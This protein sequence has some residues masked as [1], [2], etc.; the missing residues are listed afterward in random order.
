MVGWLWRAIRLDEA[1]LYCKQTRRRQRSAQTMDRSKLQDETH[2]SD[3][4]PGHPHQKL[5]DTVSKML[6]KCDVHRQR[7]RIPSSA[8]V[9]RYF[10]FISGRSELLPRILCG[11][12]D[13]AF[14]RRSLTGG[15]L[16]R[17][18]ERLRF[19]DRDRDRERERFSNT[20]NRAQ[21]RQ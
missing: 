6:C 9:S 2:W 10:D 18:F 8:S 15:D 13:S 3:L 1:S 7:D 19:R 20:E 14:R 4:V 17:D 5:R 12:S 11:D 16:G 21:S